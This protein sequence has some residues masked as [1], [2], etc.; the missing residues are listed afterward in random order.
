MNK[1][2]YLAPKIKIRSVEGEGILAASGD[3]TEVTGGTNSD[4]I[5]DGYAS[6]K[7]HYNVW[8]DDNSE[9]E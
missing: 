4:V 7:A 3:P 2:L 1:N 5:T 9:T 8:N 6:S